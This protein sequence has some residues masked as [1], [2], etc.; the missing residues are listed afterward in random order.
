MPVDIF[1][2]ARKTA[3]LAR[4]DKVAIV[5]RLA[6]TSDEFGTA[7]DTHTETARYPC[8]ITL[9]SEKEIV[10]LPVIG[11]ET[12]VRTLWRI[13]LPV[14]ANITITDKISIDGRTFTVLDSPDARSD[15]AVLCVFARRDE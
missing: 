1:F 12:V 3:L 5:L 6:A 2:S 14:E 9:M 10:S 13:Y 8:R 11:A 7:T 4:L 15:A